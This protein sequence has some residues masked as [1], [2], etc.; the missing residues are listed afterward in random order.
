MGDDARIS[1]VQHARDANRRPASQWARRIISIHE[2]VP[3]QCGVCV[4]LCRLMAATP[5]SR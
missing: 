3:P 2:W 1:L 5:I 4:T